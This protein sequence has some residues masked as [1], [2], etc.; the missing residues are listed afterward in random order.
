MKP[1]FNLT[2]HAGDV[3][4]VQLKV[5]FYSTPP[6]CSNFFF[7]FQALPVCLS[8]NTAYG[9]LVEMMLTG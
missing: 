8:N 1:S 5:L 2:E 6:T 3:N 7:K 9:E 4:Q